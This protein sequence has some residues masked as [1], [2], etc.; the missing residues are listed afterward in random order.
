M[1][2]A[3]LI[4]TKDLKWYIVKNNV[5]STLM[6]YK[7]MILFIL[8]I[9]IPTLAQKSSIS[10]FLDDGGRADAKNII[11]TD[12]SEFL[13]S[14]IQISWE[15]SFNENFSLETGIGFLAHDIYK[16]VLNKDI[17]GRPIYEDLGGGL[18]LFF[19][20]VINIK[21]LESVRH[22]FPLKFHYHFGQALSY[23]FDYTL[24]KQWFL[25][26]RLALELSAGIGFN[27]ETSIDNYS[28]IYDLNLREDFL[29]IKDGAGFRMT[30]PISVRIG[31]VL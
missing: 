20:P 26:R 14:N 11:K 18:S 9:S 31:Y 22:S 27:I 6:K 24:G 15:H 2:Y 7:I 19:C 5:R 10:T 12:L 29:S 25:T 8:F 4:Q 28:Y 1:N 16:P 17:I 30:F 21:G 13:K 3:Q 23:E